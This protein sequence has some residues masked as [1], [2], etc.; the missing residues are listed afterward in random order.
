METG[1]VVLL[2]FDGK[3]GK[4]LGK[5]AIAMAYRVPAR[6]TFG[7]DQRVASPTS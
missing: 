6:A 3:S 2:Y 4:F 5:D 7:T 1:A